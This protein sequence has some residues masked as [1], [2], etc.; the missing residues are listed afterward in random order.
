MVKTT[1]E[2]L[3]L[4]IF[5]VIGTVLL[6]F[7]AYLIG[8]RQNMFGT[9]FDIT[10][11]FKN[12]SGLQNGNNVRFSGINVGTVKKIEMINDT[13]IR[14]HMIIEEKMQE[15]IKKDAIAT[16]GSD[17]LVGSMLINIVPGAGNTE[18]I[19]Q[20]D[21]LQSY[22]KVATQ[23]MMNTLNTTN[24][25]A[26]LLTADLLKVTQALT[27]GEGTLGRLL[28]DGTMA[29][30]LQQTI[31]NLKY[32]SNHTNTTMIELN[33]IIRSINFEES[34]A[35]VLLSDTASAV[36]MRNVI[37]NLEDSS[38]EIKK[39]TQDLNTVIKGVKEGD[40][41][42]SYLSK[43]TTLVNQLN[44][45]MQHIEQGTQGFNENMKALK[46]NFLTRGYF[47]KLEKEQQKDSL[48]YSK[49]NLLQ[50]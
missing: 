40:G 30:D 7:A 32:T 45:T 6:L 1:L 46:H 49:S 48:E 9:T 34:T 4:G 23:D 14:V 50:K 39:M 44:R 2:N 19:K 43:D 37:G 31:T 20:G 16:I 35:G 25:N 3:R 26:A 38:I 8:N 22:S 10:A 15:H 36:K 24:E 5:V 41:A 33:K 17:G 18:L 28:N 42:I 47:R 21:Q 13:T 27:Q 12:A 29:N 11:T